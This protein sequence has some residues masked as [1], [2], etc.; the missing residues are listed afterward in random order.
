MPELLEALD[1]GCGGCDSLPAEDERLVRARP[2]R[3]SPDLAAGPVQVRL[4]DLE[5][6]AR[7]DRRVEGVTA[8]LEHAHPACE[9]SQCVDA[10][11]PNVPR[12][13]GRVVNTGGL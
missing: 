3:R 10:T 8:A 9:A 12:S 7:R 4:D 6:E 2:S 11:I 13:S 5:D 1:R